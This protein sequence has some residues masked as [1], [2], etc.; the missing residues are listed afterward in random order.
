[1]A[2]MAADPAV[3]AELLQ[4]SNTASPF[5]SLA[6]RVRTVAFSIAT[7]KAHSTWCI[8]WNLIFHIRN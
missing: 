1:V 5:G 8:S 7:T 4:F 3:T 6:G 2:A